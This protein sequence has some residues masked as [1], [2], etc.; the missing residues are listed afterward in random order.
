M[1]FFGQHF[2]S[3]PDYRSLIMKNIRIA[4]RPGN[5]LTL[6]ALLLSGCAGGLGT[7]R[8]TTLIE[9][10][11]EQAVCELRGTGY[12]V[13]INT[14]ARL[15]IPKAASPVTMVCQAA[16]FHPL[17]VSLKPQFNPRILGN[18][19]LVSTLGIMS[20]MIGGHDEI[21][22]KRQQLNLQPVAFPTLAARDLWF[23]GYRR[24]TLI[25][26]SMTLDA[27]SQLCDG[28]EDTVCQAIVAEQAQQRDVEIASL[29]RLRDSAQVLDELAELPRR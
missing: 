16:G 9:T 14:P 26:W 25:R 11:P 17:Q 2:Q 3:W 23:N 18:F 21:Y 20:D 7:T 15:E 27:L 4:L 10:I 22:P 19:M 28:H 6:G 12:A 29:E 5:A 24:A 8:H 13:R 1:S